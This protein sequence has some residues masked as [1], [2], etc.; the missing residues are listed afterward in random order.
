MRSFV[1]LAVL[2]GSASA[3]PMTVS[4][5]VT[6]V[7]SRWTAD[8]DRIVTEA[9]VHTATGDVTVTQF[10][11]TVDGLTMREFPGPEPLVPGMR[12]A[13]AARSDFDLSQRLHL[14]VESTKVEAYPPSYVRTGPTAAGHS[15]YWESGCVFLAVDAAGTKE[16]AG[17]VEF[18]VIDDAIAT[19]NNAIASCSYMQLINTGKKEIEVGRDN[20]NL[21]K[22]R[23]TSWCRPAV[24]DAPPHCHPDS[25]AGITTATYVDDA[26]SSR[27]G[28]IV[29]ADIE[30]NGKDFAL[31]VNGQTLGTQNCMSELQNTLTHELG[32]LLGL[33]HSCRATGDP[34]RVDDKGAAVPSCG[35][36]N[37]AQ[38]EATMFN[39]QDCGETKKETL[40][41]DDIAGVC[42]IYPLAKDPGTCDPVEDASGCAGCSSS[43]A[44]GPLALVGFLL[45]TGFWRRRR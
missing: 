26:S 17:D 10:G 20:V 18:Q 24:K 15:L 41:P 2:A 29:D 22:F 7:R 23:D 36:A 43:G 13:I 42:G 9:T 21:I 27:D 40:E 14:V 5:S 38:Q 6:D 12:V 25:A 33:E 39:F 37:Q 4:G 28:A 32:H 34:P 16:I 8:G 31:S 45:L 11:G 19:W 3:S 44:A 1:L 30:L 35:S